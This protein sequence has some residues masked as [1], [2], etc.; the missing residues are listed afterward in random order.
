MG[1]PVAG[2]HSRTVP[3]PPALASSLPSGAE[4]HRGHAAAERFAERGATGWPVAGS[5]SRT[6][7]SPPALASSLPSGLNATPATPRRRGAGLEG[8]RAGWPVTGSHSRTVP[9]L[10]A[11]ASS[12]PSGLNAT[13]ATPPPGVGLEGPAGGL[14]GNRIPQPHR[15]VSAGAGQQLAAGAERHPG[16][17]RPGR[18]AGCRSV[19]ARSAGTS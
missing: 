18:R 11:L 19:V 3:S 6:V 8:P 12:L 7:P 17:R 9:S 2:S 1:W 10:P 4:R 13:A 15:A 14:A 16:T 5:H